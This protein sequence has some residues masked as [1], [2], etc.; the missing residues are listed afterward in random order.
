MASG[1]YAGMLFNAMVW[2]WF[3]GVLCLDFCSLSPGMVGGMS[4][5]WSWGMLFLWG[6]LCVCIFLGCL[7][8]VSVHSVWWVVLLFCSVLVCCCCLF[9]SLSRGTLFGSKDW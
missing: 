6:D 8:C 9:E 1:E 2:G 5:V 7:F 4:G 3:L